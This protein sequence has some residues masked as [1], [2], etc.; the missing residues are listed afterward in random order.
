MRNV[1]ALFYEIAN[2]VEN[3]VKSKMKRMDLGEDLGIGADGTPT[4]FI[5][6]AAEQ[7]CLDVLAKK[8]KKFN[9]LSEEA[10]F[11]DNNAEKILVMDPIDGTHNA[12]RGIPFYAL[13][14]ALGK[15]RLS[16][17][18]LGLVRNLVTGDTFWAEKGS[19]AFL[20]ESP[21]KTKQYP[22]M[23]S[24]F[25]LY[26]G[27]RAT[28]QTHNVAKIPRR[29]RALGCA[30]LEMCLVASGAFDVYYQNYSPSKYSMR[31]TD[32]AASTLILREAG[33]EVFNDTYDILDMPFDL[34]SRTNVI[35]VGD[36]RAL[37]I[38]RNVVV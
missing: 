9:I 15:S 30:S 6:D 36:I 19:G 17:V 2:E 4:K 28:P 32:I 23:D 20:N 7:V 8:E 25:S 10:G 27:E 3:T 18:E 5:D 33:G 38:L 13:S 29:G 34:K 22:D 11:I 35:A 31:V 37:E 21:I 14:L 12:I 16:N 1:K 24:M 26:I